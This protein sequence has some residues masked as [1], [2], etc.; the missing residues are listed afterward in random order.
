MRYLVDREGKVA[1]RI[2]L[3]SEVW[4][5]D[6]LGDGQLCFYATT[7][8]MV[9]ISDLLQSRTVTVTEKFW[10]LGAWFVVILPA[11]VVWGMAITARIADPA[12]AE[13]SKRRITKVSLALASAAVLI[14]GIF[15]WLLRV[16]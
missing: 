11:A 2:A 3:E 15:K 9:T 10:A 6:Y 16:H 13:L 7:L 4:G 8:G 1:S 14:G 5:Y 12:T